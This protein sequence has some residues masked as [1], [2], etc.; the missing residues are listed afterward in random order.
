MKTLHSLY[1]VCVPSM[2]LENLT[3]LTIVATAEHTHT[4]IYTKWH[5]RNLL[6]HSR[7]YV[8]PLPR[9]GNRL[10]LHLFRMQMHT[11]TRYTHSERDACVWSANRTLCIP[12]AGSRAHLHTRALL[13]L[14]P[15]YYAAANG[16]RKKASCA[17]SS[18]ASHHMRRDT[19]AF[20]HEFALL[21]LNNMH[22][23]SVREVGRKWAS[24]TACSSTRFPRV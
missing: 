5:Q 9:R 6:P 23:A 3:P 24:R 18:A 17:C 8:R 2:L 16:R 10:F 13:Y 1:F 22:K 11:S 19:I 14:S 12:S 15:W 4:L 20:E 21:L 7:I